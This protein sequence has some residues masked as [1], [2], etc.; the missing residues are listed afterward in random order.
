MLKLYSNR[1]L[2]LLKLA[3]LLHC[4]PKESTEPNTYLV[5]SPLEQ[6]VTTLDPW[7]C[8]SESCA[9][10]ISAIH[11]RFYRISG[12]RILP[13]LVKVER[14]I[15]GGTLL[16]IIPGLR[17]ND[18]TLLSAYF[19]E[20]YFRSFQ[21]NGRQGWILQ[22]ISSIKSINNDELVIKHK[23][24]FEL[25]KS[26]LALPQMSIFKRNG[27]EIISLSSI[28]VTLDAS[29]VLLTK[30][31]YSINMPVI[32]DA[33]SRYFFFRSGD[34]DSLRARGIYRMLPLP[35]PDFITTDQ[36]SLSVLY[37][38]IVAG[39]N[40]ALSS[41]SFRQRLNMLFDRNSICKKS[42]LNACLPL[43]QPVPLTLSS[44]IEGERLWN[45]SKIKLPYAEI[46]IYTAADRDR[47]LIAT[48]LVSLIQSLGLSATS[49]V[50]ENA[51]LY[52][53]NNE[54]RPGIY[55]LKWVADYPHAENFLMP[56]FFSKNRGSGGNRAWFKSEEIDKLLLKSRFTD[57]E[58]I[59]LQE[60]IITY[61]PWVFI[62]SQQEKLVLRN[63]ALLDAFPR[64]YYE[65]HPSIFTLLREN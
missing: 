59:Q 40:E 14:K 64:S 2:L 25:I 50:L 43:A 1:R 26:R 9:T 8:T 34:L 42:L 48:Y 30:D 19:L 32:V 52:R 20:K 11:R 60:A 12:N 37:G 39:S 46:K 51:T 23:G 6:P 5:N 33:A 35:R 47:Q 27:K 41:I 24:S 49:Q 62:G 56:L 31:G 55:L 22:G 3:L 38:A 65:W 28:R 13:D 57:E 7:L 53:Y 4:F 45:K 36:E 61:S 54:Q 29:K 15:N 63:K 18:G 17:F 44:Q 16:K 21:A 58:V 10:V